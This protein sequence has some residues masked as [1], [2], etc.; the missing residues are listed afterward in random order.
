MPGKVADASVLAAIA[1]GEPRADEAALLLEGSLLHEPLLLP[2]ELGSVALK[3]VKAYPTQADA[4]LRSLD[5]V[6]SLEV[7]WANPH[8]ATVVRLALDT[9]LTFYD[10]CYLAV[11]RQ[12]GASL[13]TFDARLEAAS[14]ME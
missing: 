9:G 12:Q 13:V 6:L 11:A 7:N 2:F 14:T 8:Y 10:A 5:W 1:F 4:I 3:K